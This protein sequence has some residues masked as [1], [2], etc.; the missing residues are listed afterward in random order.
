MNLLSTPLAN[1]VAISIYDAPVSNMDMQPV[2]NKYNSK[3]LLR[4][5]LDLFL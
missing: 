5:S 4:D 1:P 3:E 2:V